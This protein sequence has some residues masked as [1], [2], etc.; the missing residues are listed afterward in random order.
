MIVKTDRIQEKIYLIFLQ[1]T[2]M[3]KNREFE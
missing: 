3:K 1:H 2:K